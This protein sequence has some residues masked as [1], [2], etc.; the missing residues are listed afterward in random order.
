MSASR[1]DVF[2][3]FGPLN[4]EVICMVLLEELNVLRINQ[5]MPPLTMQHIMDRM[6]NHQTDIKPYDWMK[7]P[8]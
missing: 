5:G 8:H 1:E 4:D 6:A 7:Q 3:K 2:R